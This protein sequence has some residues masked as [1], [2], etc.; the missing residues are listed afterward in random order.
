MTSGVK[1]RLCPSRL[2]LRTDFFTGCVFGAIFS[3]AMCVVLR[4]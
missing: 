1:I 4:M 2:L 3:F